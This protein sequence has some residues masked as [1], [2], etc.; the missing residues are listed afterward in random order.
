M[1]PGWSKEWHIGVRASASRKLVA[2]ISAVPV[3]LRVREKVLHASEVNFLCIHKKLRS[4]RL[5]P[6]L[7]KEIT[8]RCYTVGT[9]Q[10][11]YT[12]GVVLPTPVS[13]CRYYHRALDWEKL[14][15]VGFSPLPPNSKP[16]YQIRKYQLPQNTATSGLRPMESKDLD[17]VLDLLQRYLAKFNI[18]PIFKKDELEHQLQLKRE[19]GEEQIVWAY[20]VEVHFSNSNR[21]SSPY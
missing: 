11:I 14:Y 19:K 3:S 7:I 6:V 21:E 18:A 5:T 8:R 20:I 1:C 16:N 4:K 9:W 12:A 15:E 13:T 2:F 17:A 10:A